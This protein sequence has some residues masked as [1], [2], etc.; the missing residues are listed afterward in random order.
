MLYSVFKWMEMVNHLMMNTQTIRKVLG[1]LI[2]LTNNYFVLPLNIP[3]ITSCRSFFWCIRAKSDDTNNMRQVIPRGF[4]VHLPRHSHLLCHWTR[5]SEW[6]TKQETNQTWDVGM[7]TFFKTKIFKWF[8]LF[9][10][11]GSR[12]KEEACNITEDLLAK[13]NLTME[14]WKWM[15]NHKGWFRQKEFLNFIFMN[16]FKI[17]AAMKK[18]NCM[19][20]WEVFKRTFQT[21]ESTDFS[22]N[23]FFQTWRWGRTWETWCSGEENVY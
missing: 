11:R 23:H 22:L 20:C 10:W 16:V 3:H 6:R 13:S 19:K 2:C 7:K 5:I 17:F 1:R 9:C 15:V 18:G 8:F 4:L 14:D 21:E 12:I